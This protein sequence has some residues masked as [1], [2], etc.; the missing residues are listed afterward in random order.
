[1]AILLA[2]AFDGTTV[3]I[4]WVGGDVAVLAR[5]GRAITSTTPHTLVE[6]L[7]REHPVSELGH[8][9]NVLLRTIGERDEGPPEC[10]SAGVAPG[11]T[12]L[13]LSRSASTGGRLRPE[14]AAAIAGESAS[15]AAVAER[16]VG[17]AVAATDAP[18][19][20]VIALRFDDGAR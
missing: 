13:L 4:A 20:A 14:E 7:V 11:D 8:V 19:A 5:G 3:H 18:Y 2:A 9:P 6:R 10:L 16:L 15:P 17:A 12:L 1:M